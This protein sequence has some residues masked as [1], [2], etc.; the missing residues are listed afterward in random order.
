MFVIKVS[1]FYQH[2]DICSI[3]G[4]SVYLKRPASDLTIESL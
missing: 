3:K 1:A 2:I 4:F